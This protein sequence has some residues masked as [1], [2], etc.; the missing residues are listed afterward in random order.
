MSHGWGWRE[1]NTQVLVGEFKWKKPR[2][3][4]RHKSEDNIKMD[5]T[6][7]G[8]EN[9]NW[10]DLAQDNDKWRALVRTVTN[11]PVLDNEG[12]LLSCSGHHSTA[13]SRTLFHLVSQ[14][15]GWLVRWLVS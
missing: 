12:N 4:P 15:V 11:I 1:I 5:V 10:I 6:E 14:S 8:R 3:R 7:T 2:E 13:L 9:T